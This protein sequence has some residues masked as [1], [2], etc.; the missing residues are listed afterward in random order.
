MAGIFHGKKII[1]TLLDLDFCRPWDPLSGSSTPRKHGCCSLLPS[2]GT[3]MTHHD[4]CP[5]VVKNLNFN[6]DLHIWGW[7]EIIMMAL[8]R[9]FVASWAGWQ[10]PG[11][12]RN[13][14]SWLWK[15]EL[16][17][18]YSHGSCL[19]KRGC[20]NYWVFHPID[21][22]SIQHLLAIHPIQSNN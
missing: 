3:P 10:G 5:T 4:S 8:W 1:S 16:V 22:R 21:S 6:A 14:G 18:R 9:P 20:F 7:E 12:M 15:G 17:I 2:W 11:S 19:F 13:Q